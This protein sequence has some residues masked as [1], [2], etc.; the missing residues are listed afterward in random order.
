MTSRAS[1][2]V[3]ATSLVRC[4]AMTSP[5]WRC[6]SIAQ[7]CDAGEEEAIEVGRRL[8]VAQRLERLQE[9]AQLAARDRAATLEIGAVA[10]EVVGLFHV[11]GLD[12]ARR[13]HHLDRFVA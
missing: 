9:C 6:R 2:S 12:A 13:R 11:L 1:T 10:E 5:L 8:D 3:L 4:V 7:A